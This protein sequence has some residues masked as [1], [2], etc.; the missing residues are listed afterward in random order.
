MSYDLY[1]NRSADLSVEEFSAY[2]GKVPHFKV[3]GSQAVYGNEDTGV[4]FLF[5]LATVAEDEGPAHKISL[6]LNYY[7][8]HFFGLEAAPVLKKVVDDFQFDIHDPQN[9]GMGDGPFSE[10]GFLRG[11]NAG[12]AFGYRAILK[13]EQPPAEIHTRPT[14]EL[15]AIW[16]WNYEKETMQ[17]T[18]GER[19]FVPKVFWMVADGVL[20]S[21]AVWPDGI[22]AL[23]PAVDLYFIGRDELAPKRFF[24]RT[25]D[26]CLV[27][28]R[29]IEAA[30]GP[31][32][33]TKYPLP[34]HLFDHGQ[35]P[36][37]VRAFVEGLIPSNITKSGVA[38]DQV[39][40]R[41]LVVQLRNQ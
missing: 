6:N 35:P 1:F 5:D 2:F 26:T 10:E 17:E 13:S 36:R 15:E 39:L 25:K 40:N 34:H 27:P 12:N 20:C 32:V 22:A 9:S 24:M 8:P 37:E 28:R 3:E 33:S 31:F 21:T 7:R 38:M 29:E 19:V 4:Y 23:V 14:A 30:F 18:F 16:R 41:E 11:W